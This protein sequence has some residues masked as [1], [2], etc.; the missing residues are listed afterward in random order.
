MLK[1]SQSNLCDWEKGRSE[2]DLDKLKQMSEILDT[3]VDYLIGNAE[4][5]SSMF[6]YDFD[7]SRKSS[8][9]NL[10]L[11]KIETMDEKQKEALLTLL[12]INAP[13]K[14]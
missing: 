11:A 1:I 12:S 9:H 5:N 3:T 6:E 14:K 2:P 4:D 8:V 10:L 13:P 7:P